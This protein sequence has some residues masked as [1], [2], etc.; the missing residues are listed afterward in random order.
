M[1]DPERSFDRKRDYINQLIKRWNSQ[2]LDESLSEFLLRHGVDVEVPAVQYGAFGKATV[3]EIENIP[4][5]RGRNGWLADT[6]EG[7]Y[8]WHGDEWVKDF[9]PYAVLTPDMI[10]DLRDV[11][12]TSS[13]VDLDVIE[14]G[15]R[16]GL[17]I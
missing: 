5:L 1:R 2:S 7:S 16:Q 9:V 15:R 12:Q 6:G 3:R 4:V 13:N 17:D 14:W 10:D 11:L 8:W